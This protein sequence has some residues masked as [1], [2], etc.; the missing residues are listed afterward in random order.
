MMIVLLVVVFNQEKK[1]PPLK[2]LIGQ[3]IPT[4]VVEDLR[5]EPSSIKPIPGKLL[6]LNVWATWCA[7]CRHEMPALQELA[8]KLGSERFELIGL[9]VDEDEFVVREFLIENEIHFPSYL[10]RDMSE[11]KGV[12]GVRMF[13]STFFIHP[14]GALVKVIEGWQEWE[15]PEMIETVRNLLP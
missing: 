5:N 1:I 12:F 13:P 7:P 6:M 2:V 4:L 14:N 9:S 3:Q 10:D 11:A 15:T 8:Q